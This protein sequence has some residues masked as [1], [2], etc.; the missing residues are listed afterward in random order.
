MLK[1]YQTRKDR[2]EAEQRTVKFGRRNPTAEIVSGEFIV[3]IDPYGAV[4]WEKH[5]LKVG[6]WTLKNV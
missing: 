2:S 1:L 3:R 5:L 6:A 4:F